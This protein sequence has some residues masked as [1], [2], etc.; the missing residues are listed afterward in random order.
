MTSSWTAS[1][2]NSECP[3]LV[4]N[5]DRHMPY[6]SRDKATLDRSATHTPGPWRV[7]ASSRSYEIWAGRNEDHPRFLAEIPDVAMG[8]PSGLKDKANAR[9]IAAAPELLEALQLIKSRAGGCQLEPHD[10]RDGQPVPEVIAV[11]EIY[12]WAKAALARLDKD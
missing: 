5:R 3:A 9:L 2:L 7:S 11:E 8:S 4:R 12:Q 1:V 10:P 6:M